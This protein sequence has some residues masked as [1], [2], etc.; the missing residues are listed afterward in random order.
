MTMNDATERTKSLLRR[1]MINRCPL[2]MMMTSTT[3][4]FNRKFK[5]P[6]PA[7]SRLT[8]GGP[9]PI[10]R[11]DVRPF[12]TIHS[13]AFKDKKSLRQVGWSVPEGCGMSLGR[14]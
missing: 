12:Y 14:A 13:P 1:S 7:V 11:G 8:D 9:L 4:D 6:R 5:P 10:L 3:L 2:L